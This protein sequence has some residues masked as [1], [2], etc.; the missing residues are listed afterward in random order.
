MSDY[1]LVRWVKLDKRMPPFDKNDQTKNHFCARHWNNDSKSYSYL[2]ITVLSKTA[3]VVGEFSKV[4]EEDSDLAK[5]LEWMEVLE[6]KR[7]VIESYIFQRIE[8]IKEK[9]D[10][11]QKKKSDYTEIDYNKLMHAYDHAIL[12]L[13][14]C[15]TAHSNPMSNKVLI[16]DE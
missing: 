15:I 9:I 12:Q 3:F 6:S 7:D 14:I 16:G 11:L 2:H 10:N 13:L 5:I 1:R 4:H 8:T